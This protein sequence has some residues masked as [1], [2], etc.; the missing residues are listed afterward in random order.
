MADIGDKTLLGIEKIFE[1][2]QGLVEGF[3]QVAHLIVG[4][5]LIGNAA[6]KIIGAV[7]GQGGLRGRI[8]RGKRASKHKP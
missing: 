5:A 1:A 2:L 4:D 8:Q 7:D 6:R 3:D